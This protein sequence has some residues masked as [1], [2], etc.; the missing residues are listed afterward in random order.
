[1][2]EI[3][4]TMLAGLMED[5]RLTAEA[6]ILPRF[7]AVLAA[8]I[9]TKSAP[10]D[11]VTDADL[12][13]E[14]M[15]GEKLPLRLPGIVMVGE[16]AVAN[17]KTILER[18]GTAALVAV[19]DPV[20]GTWNF[21]HGVPLFGSILAIIS[22]GRTVAGLIHYP[23]TGDFV[24]ARPGTGA[25]HVAPDGVRTR[26]H[27]AAPSPIEDMHGFVPLHMYPPAMQ[28]ELAPRVL[29]FSRTTTWRCSAF[30]YR[31]LATGAMSFCVNAGLSPWDHAAGVLIHAE[32]GGHAALLTGEPYAPTLTE[33]HLLLAPDAESW[34]AVR[35]ALVE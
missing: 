11:L 26:L 13:A 10:D 19:V 6:E 22:D 1:M 12:G 29:R 21:A 20:D 5:M 32:A 28:A 23:V 4:D 9:R 16:E 2:I 33:G 17:D 27:V 3:D 34:A 35:A 30:E 8:A 14:R 18:I 25:W 31:M 7:N 24:V 15:L